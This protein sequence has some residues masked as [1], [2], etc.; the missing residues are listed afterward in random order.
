MT[1]PNENQERLDNP[2]TKFEQSD[3][4][5]GR[6]ALWGMAAI[7]A[8]IFIAMLV[9]FFFM[10]GMT[11]YRTAT[12]PTP[13]PLIDS[14]PTPP[15]PRLQPNPNDQLTAEQELIEFQ[16]EEE[17][18][19]NSFGWVNKEAGIVRIPIGRAIQILAEDA[20]PAEEPGK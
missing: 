17:Y 9:V 8:L 6:V 5:T 10:G 16:A 1:E 3:V 4:M 14:R 20:S 11:S 13:L 2:E 12:D 15:A 18:I 19:L 7:I